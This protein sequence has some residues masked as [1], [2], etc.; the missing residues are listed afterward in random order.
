[1]TDVLAD[2]GA[3]ASLADGATAGYDA[4][5][6]FFLAS[7]DGNYTMQ[8]KGEMQVR[9]AYSARDIGAVDEAEGSPSDA[10]EE[11]AWGFEIRRMRMTFS[12]TVVDPSWYYEVKFEFARSGGAAL[13][14]DALI[15]K[16]FDNG[17]N[18]RV[19]QFKGPF[20]RESIDSATGLLAVERSL[21]DTFFTVG[22]PQGMRL[23]WESDVVR[24]EGF[25]GSELA[26]AGSAPYSIVGGS[27][28]EL[29][30]GSALG[31][32]GSQNTGFNAVQTD[33]AFIGRVEAKT[34]GEW[35]QFKDMQSYR[36]EEA[37]ALF[38]VAAYAQQVDAI[39][40]TDGATPD[41]MWSVTADARVDFGGANL[42][43]YGVYRDVSL[44]EAQP[45][46]GGGDSDELQQ[47]GAV[48]QGGYFL[49]ETVEGFLRYEVGNSDTDK[50]RTA[51]GTLEA[52][53]DELS[54]LTVGANWWPAGVKN[55]V[56][57]SGD[58][59]YAFTPLVDFAASGA[60]WLPN[61]TE[62]DGDTLGGEWVIR[63]QLQFTF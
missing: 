47:W 46:R 19:G 36:G 58:F 40:G 43:A 21:V 23:A 38:G 50:F 14:S 30:A 45:V 24:V 63:T 3:R 29:N 41:V 2:A 22:R 35:K 52:D 44:Q 18:L 59:G 53:G 31:I 6:G 49:T 33:Y 42:F 37:A 32:P 8:M 25:Y 27:A 62:E 56:K 39:S 7:A 26:A 10:T 34:G 55:R 4:K 48:A 60:D 61:Y 1:M 57:I 9:W 11:D 17:F 16:R 15:E 28:S 54:L 5:K 20:L 51:P 13:L 12:G